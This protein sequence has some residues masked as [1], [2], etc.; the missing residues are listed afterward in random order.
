M[1]LELKLKIFKEKGFTYNKETGEIFSHKGVLIKWRRKGYLQCSVTTNGLRIIIQAHQLAWYLT[2]GE[3]PKIID[4][5]NRIKDDNR[6]INLRNV[7]FQQNAFNRTAKGYTW[8]KSSK[9]WRAYI[10]L[11]G[12][13]TILGYFVSET[14][15]HDAYLEAKKVYHRI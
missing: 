11:D 2:T 7:T 1:N 5:I 14:E 8:C 9:K 10:E 3:V 6:F 12:K 13:K 4:H 15:A